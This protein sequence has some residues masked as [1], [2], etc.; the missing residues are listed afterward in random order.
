MIEWMNEICRS[1]E[2]WNYGKS[3]N[4]SVEMWEY[5]SVGVW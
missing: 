2:L 3:I 4:V 5:G 1:V